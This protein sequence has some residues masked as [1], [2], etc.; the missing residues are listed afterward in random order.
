[1]N[2]VNSIFLF[3]L[4]ISIFK[5]YKYSSSTPLFKNLDMSIQVS[6][7]ISLSLLYLLFT[8]LLLVWFACLLV[9]VGKQNITTT[10]DVGLCMFVTVDGLFWPCIS[11]ILVKVCVVTSYHIVIRHVQFVIHVHMSPQIIKERYI[12]SPVIAIFIELIINL[13]ILS[14]IMIYGILNWFLCSQCFLNEIGI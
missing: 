8:Y 6:M 3:Y 7:S 2:I 9:C 5:L 4:T 10:L 11:I 1:M 13:D 14:F 12:M